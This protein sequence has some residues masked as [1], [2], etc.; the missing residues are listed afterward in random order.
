MLE[1]LNRITAAKEHLDRQ[2]EKSIET[3]GP[4]ARWTDAEIK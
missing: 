4:V 1:K 2:F 3:K